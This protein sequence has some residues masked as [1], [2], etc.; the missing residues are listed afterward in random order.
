MKTLS[1]PNDLEYRI[2]YKRKS[3]LVKR[4]VRKVKKENW[5]RCVSEIEYDIHGSQ[6]KAYKIMKH[7]NKDARDTI[8]LNTIPETEWLDYF[9]SLWTNEDEPETNIN[10]TESV[11]SITMEEM[12]TSIKEAKN[13]KAPGSDTINIELIKFASEQLLQ[14]LL[15]FINTC[16]FCG[17]VP[18]EWNEALIYPI[19]KKGDISECSNYRG[20]SLLNTCYKLYAKIIN[21]RLVP[22]IETYIEEYQHGFRKGRSCSDCIFTLAQITE[23]RREFNLPTYYIFIDYEKAFDRVRRS[24]LWKI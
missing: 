8:Q 22:I 3:D 7:L 24:V 11:D 2:D 15:N 20:I 14:R 5:E 10:V 17:Y 12:K 13:K 6:N 1:N 4:E 9:K 18:E 21:K 19:H 16:W 23:K